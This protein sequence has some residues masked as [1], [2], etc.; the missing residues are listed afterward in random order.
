[1][2]ATRGA[3]KREGRSLGRHPSRFWHHLQHP[4]PSLRRRALPLPA[5]TYPSHFRGSLTHLSSHT[6]CPNY[7]CPSQAPFLQRHLDP[8]VSLTRIYLPSLC[9]PCTPSVPRARHFFLQNISSHLWR[10]QEELA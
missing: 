7:L 5:P 4:F 3:T 1:M 6:R 2:R 8:P 10:G 9:F